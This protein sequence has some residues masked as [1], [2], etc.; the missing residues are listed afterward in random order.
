MKQTMY[1]DLKY[2][3]RNLVMMKRVE[4]KGI[5]YMVD[6]W[7]YLSTLEVFFSFYRHN[8]LLGLIPFG[9]YICLLI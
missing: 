3:M 2:L 1:A 7:H 6:I 5:I 8:A 9:V 4:A